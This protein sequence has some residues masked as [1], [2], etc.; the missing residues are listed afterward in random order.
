MIILVKITVQ[1]PPPRKVLIASGYFSV[2]LVTK[3]FFI[4]LDCQ[5]EKLP[6]R[7]RDRSR[8]ID[9][10]KHAHKFCNTEDEETIYLR[11]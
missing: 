1:R 2:T 8:V 3:S 7:P 4:P 6:M 10:A 9:G 11:R 5:L